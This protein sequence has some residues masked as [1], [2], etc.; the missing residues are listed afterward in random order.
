MLIQLTSKTAKA[1]TVDKS[2]DIKQVLNSVFHG[3]NKKGPKPPGSKRSSLLHPAVGNER[4]SQATNNSLPFKVASV[5]ASQG[6]KDGQ[7]I[8]VGTSG[9]QSI[10]DMST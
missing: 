3:I 7:S 6:L 4:Q 5:T 2:F 8:F 1:A 10:L 9:K